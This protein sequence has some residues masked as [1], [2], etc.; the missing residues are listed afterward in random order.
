V[1]N[2]VS[3]NRRS[4][5]PANSARYV[6]KARIIDIRRERRRAA[7]GA[8]NTCDE[9][10][11]VGLRCHLIGD[12]PRQRCRAEVQLADK[13]F[14]VIIGLRHRRRIERIGADDIG[15]GQQV[16]PMNVRDDLRLRD[17][18]KVVVAP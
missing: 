16:V 18:E 5:P 17:R 3:I 4:T 6:A 14:Q 2:I 13:I 15:A 10:L 7:G 1:S 8:Q 12:L 9:A 11:L